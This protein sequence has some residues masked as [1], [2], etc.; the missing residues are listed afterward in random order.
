MIFRVT[1]SA[2]PPLKFAAEV[3]NS[4]WCFSSCQTGV[5]EDKMY[6][7]CQGV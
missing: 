7:I 4:I 2:D 5:T 1:W 3:R 6:A